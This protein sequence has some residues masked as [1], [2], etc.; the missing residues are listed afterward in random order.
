MKLNHPTQINPS[1]AIIGSVGSKRLS[2]GRKSSGTAKLNK[3]TMS[4][5]LNLGYSKAQARTILDLI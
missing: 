2:I 3:P 5:L 4:S 1:R